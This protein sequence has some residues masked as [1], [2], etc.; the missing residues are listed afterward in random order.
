MKLQDIVTCIDCNY[1]GA[2]ARVNGINQCPQ[3]ASRSIWF[4]SCWSRPPRLTGPLDYQTHPD[5]H[6][7]CCE[8]TPSFF[9]G[10]EP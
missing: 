8:I 2:P 4:I 3:C 6:A 1:A 7:H 10:T 9:G 5:P